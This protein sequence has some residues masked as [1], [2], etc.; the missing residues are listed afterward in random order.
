VPAKIKGEVRP[1]D[2]KIGEFCAERATPMSDDPPICKSNGFALQRNDWRQN[3]AQCGVHLGNLG[4]DEWD[5]AESGYFWR[6]AGAIGR[7]V[8]RGGY[9]L[10]KFWH[11]P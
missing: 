3:Y 2:G 7:G 8:M 9:L 6:L 11:N 5:R 4:L 10:S 1:D